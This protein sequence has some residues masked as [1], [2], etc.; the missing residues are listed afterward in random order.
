MG[1]IRNSIDRI[2]IRGH[3]SDAFDDTD[4]DGVTVEDENG[5]GSIVIEW[6]RHGLRRGDRVT[7]TIE[8][9]EREV[10]I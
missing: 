4:A 6:H 5:C 7:V 3:V 1:A 2:V 8:K 10:A 9:T